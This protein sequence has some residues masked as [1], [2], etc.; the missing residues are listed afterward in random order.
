MSPFL[1]L[2]RRFSIRLRMQAAIAMVLALFALVGVTG[3]L[4]GNKLADLNHEFIEHSTKEVQNLSDVNV[5][6][7]RV[8]VHEKAMIIDYQDGLA[9]LKHR[10]AW[11]AEIKQVNTALG[12]LLEGE[13]DADNPLARAALKDLDAYVKATQE[14]LDKMQNGEYDDVRVADKG[15]EDA[16][17]LVA[18]VGHSL[19]E[20][21]KIVK[22]EAASSL[23]SFSAWMQGMQWAFGA[24]M[25]LAVAIVVPLTLMNSRS[26]TDPI[27]HAR[28]VAL[29]IAGGNLTVE[30]QTSGRDETAD[31]LRALAHM[32][33]ELGSVVSDVRRA[34]DSIHVA[35]SEVASGNTDLSQR[36]E[37]TASSLQQTALSMQQLTSS[38]R[39]SADAAKNADQLA[40]SASFAAERGGEVVAKVVHTMGDIHT[41]SRKIADIIGVIDGIAF[42]TNILALNAAVEAARAGEQGRGFAVVASEVRSLAG[43][44]AEAARE[45][46]TL[47]QASVERIDGGTQLVQNAGSTMADIVQSVQR[48]THTIQDITQAAAQQSDGISQVNGAVS[49]L[50]QMTQQ[51]AALVEQ[52]AAA[53]QSLRDQAERLNAVV[54]RFQ[55]AA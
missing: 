25:V 4:G 35:S 43:R 45:I 9:V 24:A 26:I 53:A 38:V 37:T 33:Q 11:L 40:S 15:L 21:S 31:L 22:D 20:I 23:A 46:K 10:E 8:R 32:Q 52:S 42:Q 1:G 17:H 55:L 54:A 36:T 39:Q 7:G 18:K 6:L 50:D 51:N 5:A 12:S 30:I 48:V 14:V 34:S 19:A 49:H 29:A 41:A 44:S 13:E 27:N 47:I 3:L 28:E 2:M 16:K